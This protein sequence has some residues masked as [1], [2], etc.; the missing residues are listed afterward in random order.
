VNDI[1][2][3]TADGQR[4]DWPA[5][6]AGKAVV[7]I[8]IKDG[9]PCSIRFEPYFHR[10]Y[11]AYR[12]TVGFVG[13]I[14]GEGVTARS[15]AAANAVPYKLIA[16]PDA[17]LM[18]R[19]DAKNGGYAALLDAGGVVVGFWPGFS[20]DAMADLGRRIALVAGIAERPIETAGLPVKL[21]SGCAFDRHSNEGERQRQ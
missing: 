10:L 19:F 21:T 12:G 18:D 4:L 11:E 3:I 8:F 5:L 20:V 7:L 13:V 1:T 16:D 14:D 15:Y 17:R 6:S 2:A 9:C